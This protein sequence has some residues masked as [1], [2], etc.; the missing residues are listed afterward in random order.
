MITAYKNIF[1]KEPHY[2]TIDKCLERIKDG[3]SKIKVEE[4]RNSLSKERANSLKANLP[5]ICFSGKF[6]EGRTDDSLI[7]HS[8]YI[9]LD[10]DNVPDVETLKHELI[11]NDFIKATWVSPSGNGVKALVVIAD[12]SKHKEHFQALMDLFPAIDKSGINP[13]RVCYESYDADIF[14]S[15][16]V[17]PF[18]K[19]KSINRVK[20]QVIE[21][22]NEKIFDRILKWLTNKGDA[23]VTG[24]RNLFIF[25]LASACCRFGLDEYETERYINNSIL[26]NDNSFSNS[27]ALQ[28]IKSAF[29]SNSKQSGTAVFEN[30]ILVERTNKKEVQINPDIYDSSIRPKDVLFGE[31]VKHEAMALYDSGYE[32]AETTEVKELDEYW[33]WKKGELTLLSGIGNYGKSSFL[34]YILLIKSMRKGYKWALFAPE[35]FPAHEFYHDLVEIFMGEDMTPRNHDRPARIYYEQVYDWVSKHFFFVYPKDISSTPEYIKERFLELII[36]EKVNGVVIDPFNQLDNDYSKV[37]GRDDKYLEIVLADFKRFAQVNNV[38]FIIVA[39]PKG[40][41]K[42]DNGGNYECPDVFDL[43][44]GAMWNNKVD[45]ILIYHRP[46]RGQLP[47]AGNC[48]IHTKKI[49]RQKTVGKIGILEFSLK[50]NSRRYIWSNETDYIDIINCHNNQDTETPF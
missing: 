3:A 44:G 28:T 12:K 48:E 1:S 41:L 50:K 21:T 4:I 36:K 45:N 49:R 5:S 32:S 16:N 15:D 39:H 9:V 2:T 30:D 14:V 37:G 47:E 34:K 8:G 22:D 43:A 6:G 10:F 46:L 40:G 20:E 18:T 29:K 17:T 38:P 13:S 24:E 25:K 42:K 26:I 27:E 31:D 7:E 11:S 33:K 35:D 19:L 23:F